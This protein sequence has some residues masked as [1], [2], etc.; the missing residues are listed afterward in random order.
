MV[1][2]FALGY[3]FVRD[4]DAGNGTIGNFGSCYG[5]IGYLYGG[6]RSRIQYATD[7]L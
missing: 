7:H 2:D 1:Y 5:T 4:F 3:F 6:Y